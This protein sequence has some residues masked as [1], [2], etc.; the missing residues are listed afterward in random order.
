[1]PETDG[2]M[3]PRERIV[4]TV[5]VWPSATS[6]AGPAAAAGPGISALG[7]TPVIDERD[8]AAMVVTVHRALGML[9]RVRHNQVAL[10]VASSCSVSAGPGESSE[11]RRLVVAR[12]RVADA[13]ALHVR[14][15]VCRQTSFSIR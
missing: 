10:A 8:G 11:D 14:I 7:R 13:P 12:G 3:L 1:M 4:R 6:F 2:S 5:T 9:R 15:E